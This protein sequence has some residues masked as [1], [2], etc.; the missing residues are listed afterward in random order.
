VTDSAW[1]PIE[2]DRLPDRMRHVSHPVSRGLWFA[3]DPDLL[4]RRPA[5]GIVGSR[6]PRE[7]ARSI[8]RRIARDA[9]RAGFTIVSGL[10]IGVDGLAHQQALEHGAPTI[11]VL[12]GGLAR[13][14]PASN[15]TLARQI[16]GTSLP[17]GVVAGPAPGARGLLVSEY[18]PG[19][20]ETRPH[21]FQHRNRIIAALSDYLVVVQATPKS[22][23][24]GTAGRALELGVP[25]GVVPSA[26]D[27]PSYGGSIELIQQGA[28]AVVDGR[29]LFLRL[30]L[31]GVM[32]PGFAAAAARGAI[33]DPTSPG[34]WT[35]GGEAE[36]LALPDHPLA[37]ILEV[38]RTADEVAELAGLDLRDARVM[39]LELEDDGLVTHRDDGA[40]TNAVPAGPRPTV[41]G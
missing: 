36:Q 38:P 35:G 41:P 20:E 37:S 1:I 16:A 6:H 29:S 26:P 15:R 17:A 4:R 11:G 31:Q 5:I 40:W 34:S 28:D 10:A 30:E 3:G 23:S 9:A 27:D 32:R 33:V 19:E 24:M 2:D 8:A 12:A 21:Q 7:E 22:G 39:L 18:G 14:Y 13:V 25:I